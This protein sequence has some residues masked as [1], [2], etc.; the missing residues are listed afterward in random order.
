MSTTYFAVSEKK[1]AGGQKAIKGAI[2]GVYRNYRYLAGVISDKFSARIAWSAL[3][4][5]LFTSP[6]KGWTLK[7]R[8][9]CSAISTHVNR[10]SFTP[11]A[12]V[13]VAGVDTWT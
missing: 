4:P 13:W 7:A 12:L 11:V 5:L 2:R 10:V 8:K 1:F 6:H 9:R 3:L